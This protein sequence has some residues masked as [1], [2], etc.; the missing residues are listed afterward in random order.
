LIADEDI[1]ANTADTGDDEVLTLEEFEAVEGGIIEVDRGTTEEALIVSFDAYEGPLDVLLTLARTQKVDLKQISVL[2]LAEQYLEFVAEARKV[3]LELAADYLVMAAWLAFLKSKLIIPAEETEDG[4]LSGEELAARLAFRL[5]RLEAMRKS[6][7]RLFARDRLGRDF[8]FRGM[9]EGIRTIKHTSYDCSLYE[10][11][12]A[13]GDERSRTALANYSPPRPVVFTMEMALKRLKA[14]VGVVPDW[15]TLINFLP[16][17][18][19]GTKQERRSAIAGTF[20]ASL[21]MVREG[22]L[23]LRQTQTYGPIFIRSGNARDD[24]ATPAAP[25]ENSAPSDDATSEDEHD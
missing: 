6:A 17:G 22:K 15:T 8:F 20:A 5:Q 14:I 25:V 23:E 3:R 13:Y 9:P 12:K 18:W 7:A 16:D 21:E 24:R 4:E 11:L 19:E 2:A 1:A 10:L